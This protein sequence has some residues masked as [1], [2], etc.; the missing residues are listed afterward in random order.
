MPKVTQKYKQESFDKMLR[1]FKNQCERAGIVKRVRE[2]EYYDKPNFKR[3][4]RNQELKRTKKNNIF[5]AEKMEMRRKQTQR[6]R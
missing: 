1:R 4:R 2:L 3:N 6:Y 5:K